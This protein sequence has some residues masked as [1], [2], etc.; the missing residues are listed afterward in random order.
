M[1]LIDMF[2][3]RAV[4]RGQLTLHRPGKAPATFGTPD[5]AFGHITIR[6]ADSGVAGRIIRNP[7]LAAGEMYMDGRLTVDGDDIMGLVKLMTGN[8]P[9]ER[10]QNAL[11]PSAFVRGLGAVKH[12]LDRINMERRS[13]QNVAHH[14]DLSARLYDLFLDADKQYSCA[15][16]TDPD[17]SL[18]QAQSDKL[19]HI[20]AKLALRPGMRVLDIGC[21]W[22]GMALY[23]NTHFGVEVLGV[24]LSEEQ[25]KI[26]R[27]RAAAA[28]VADK[29]KFELIDYRRVEGRFDRIVSVGMFEHV[30]PPQYKTYFR[31]CRDLLTDDGVALVHTIGRFGPPSVTDDW[32]TKYIF[33]GGYNPALSETIAAFEGLSMFLTDV[34]V[35]RLHYAYTLHEWYA[36][37]L[38]ARDAIV[39]LYDERFYRMWTFYLAGAA[40]AFEN[41]GLCNFQI[42]FSRSRTELPIVRDY[43][44]EGERALRGR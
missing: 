13:K 11:Q 28:G 19:A 22:G 20:A 31:K 30:G 38:K 5:P 21:G 25:L 4:K 41:G 8:S 43:M 27:E 12:R 36:R 6:F 37:T 33:P 17:N 40:M 35:L 39:A 15:Y 34:E 16:Y 44:V 24:T 42:Q 26:A 29:V 9:W 14:Y 1:A 23:L 7:A 2:L 10:G 3:S 18:E 32:T